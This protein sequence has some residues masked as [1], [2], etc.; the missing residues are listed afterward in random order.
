MGT[1][2]LLLTGCTVD[3]KKSAQ[4]AAGSVGYVSVGCI[5]RMD[6]FYSVT[7]FLSF[8]FRRFFVEQ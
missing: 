1:L 4:F 6:F 7:S 2:L 3:W 5:G 8:S